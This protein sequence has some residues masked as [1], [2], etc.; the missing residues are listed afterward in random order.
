LRN[1]LLQKGSACIK[2]V[3]PTLTG[4]SDTGLSIEKGDDASLT[5]FK[6]VTGSLNSQEMVQVREDLEDYCSLDTQGANWVVEELNNI[7]RSL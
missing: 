3:L 2:H 1:L 5:F 4:K 6:M 7:C